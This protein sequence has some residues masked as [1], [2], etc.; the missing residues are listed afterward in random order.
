MKIGILGSRGIPNHY[1]GYEQ[2]AQHLSLGLVERGHQVFVY[3]SSLH[4][5]QGN[6]WKNVELIPKWDPENYL[7]SF[8]QFIYD[9]LS[10]IDAR[11][12][13][14]HLLFQLGYTS[15]AIFYPLWPKRCPNF[16]HMDGLEW[17]RSKYNPWVKRFLKQMER[18]A[19]KKG[20]YLIADSVEIKK[21]LEL[22][23]QKT[24]NYIPY[25]AIVPKEFNLNVLSTYQLNPLA[26]YLAIARFVPENN[27][28]LIIKGYLAS[29]SSYPLV[30]IGNY[31][32]KYG[33]YL[34]SHYDHPNIRFLGA[35]YD[36]NVLNNL[37]HFCTLYFHGHSV[38][39]TN[40]SLLEAM[41]CGATI[42]AHENPFNFA[43]LGNQ[44]E[45]FKNETDI[46]NSLRKQ[47]SKEE[48]LSSMRTSQS[49]I[50][51]KYSWERI[52]DQYERYF[53]NADYTR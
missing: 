6:Q 15:S 33:A 22:S 13:E 14:L 49:I 21:H 20:D 11:K 12:R 10:L 17:K 28:E 42:V 38:G 31:Q 47:R 27:L 43:V 41:A 36:I 52:I 18:I 7:G 48:R 37:R 34:K 23:Y 45:Y 5:Y 35:I 30:L 25:G 2:F 51:E 53:L 50:R 29:K 8:G 19:A 39:G 24:A 40:P 44:S 32:T 26:Y 1:G 46:Q 9:F 3:Q 4:P 16:I